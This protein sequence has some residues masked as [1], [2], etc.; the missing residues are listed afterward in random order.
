MGG[1]VWMGGK[2]GSV[3]CDGGRWVVWCVMEVYTCT[4]YKVVW[5]G[6]GCSV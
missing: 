3:V 2:V 1:V 5:C 6:L 4:M